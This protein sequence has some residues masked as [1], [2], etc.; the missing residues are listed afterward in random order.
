MKSFNIILINQTYAANSFVTQQSDRVIE[1]SDLGTSTQTS[2]EIVTVIVTP[3]N[4][5]NEK[6][7]K[8]KADELKSGLLEM[9]VRFLFQRRC[10]SI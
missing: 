9:I 4:Y 2:F 10:I 1:I 5:P 3:S 7:T 6:F 8:E